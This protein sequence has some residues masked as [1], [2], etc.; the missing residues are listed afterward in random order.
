[1]PLRTSQGMD[2]VLSLAWSRGHE[3]AFAAVD[4][5]LPQQFAE[6]AALAIQVARAR[7]DQ[8][9]LLVL[10][11]RDRIGRDLHDLVIQRLF[12]VGLNLEH[13]ARHVGDRPDVADRLISAVDDLD[14][15]IRDIRRSIFALGSTAD[16]TDIRTSTLEAAE[17]AARALKF[18]P[19]VRFSGPVNS[20]VTPALAEQ[21]LAVLGEA[22]S[23][24]VK[25]AGATHASVE[26]KAGD[27][28]ELIVSDDG[29]GL[30]DDAPQSGL[31]N[32]RERAERLG[33]RCHVESASGAGTTISWSVP[34]R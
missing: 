15:T 34:A 21:V 33:G 8:E 18:R 3:A 30:R 2:G 11:D 20:I 16:S 28:V 22:L 29:R 32:I 13:T 25:H 9:K 6:Q 27:D 14:D 17:R 24:M 10:E 4:I 7:A 12:A 31:R 26:L 1:L 23:N 19:E 5:R